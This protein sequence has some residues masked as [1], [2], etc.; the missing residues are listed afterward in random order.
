VSKFAGIGLLAAG[1]RPVRLQTLAVVT[2]DALIDTA[3]ARGAWA[4]PM[5]PRRSINWRVCHGFN[6][7]AAAYAV[8]RRVDDRSRGRYW[9][10]RERDGR[11]EQ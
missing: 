1:I 9:R 11:F 2:A 6:K 5:G 3:P 8:A 7:A 4:A 10:Y